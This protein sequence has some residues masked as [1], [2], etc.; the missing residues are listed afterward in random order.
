MGRYSAAKFT[1]EKVAELPIMR[2]S[3][4]DTWVDEAE[5]KIYIAYHGQLLRVPLP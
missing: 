5:R 4:T 2:L 1:F 3:S